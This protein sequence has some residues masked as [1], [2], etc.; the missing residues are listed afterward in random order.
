MTIPWRIQNFKTLRSTQDYIKSITPLRHGTVICT[1]EQSAGHGRHGR[2]WHGGAG[3]LFLS[4]ALNRGDIP[5]NKV[6]MLALGTGVALQKTLM[7]YLPAHI[8]CLIKW[9]NDILIEGR[10]TAGL[11]LEV[12]NDIVVIGIGLNVK[13]APQTEAATCLYNHG[14]SVS[15]LKLR[16]T[17]LTNINDIYA[18]WITQKFDTIRL[19]F[20]KN[21][22]DIGTRMSVK[23]GRDIRRGTFIGI[24]NH[25]E[26]LISDGTGAVKTITAGDVFVMN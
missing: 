23:I 11:L 20:I 12:H 15:A 4:L 7:E 18:L 16:E 17:L 2:I 8:K 25:G 13:C 21:T 26:L 19:G 24:N 9:P 14:A 6:G 3:N 1:A 5:H 22:F 10:K